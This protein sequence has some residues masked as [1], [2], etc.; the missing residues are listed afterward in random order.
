MSVILDD[1]T[2][3]VNSS[4]CPRPMP[5][6]SNLAYYGGLDTMLLYLRNYTV[7]IYV[8]IHAEYEQQPE[9][10]LN[11]AEQFVNNKMTEQGAFSCDVA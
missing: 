4:P 9:G 1:Q 6:I 5:V 7:D 8:Y 2:F 10:S 11:W 3:A